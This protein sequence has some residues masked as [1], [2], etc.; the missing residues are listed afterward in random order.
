MVEHLLSLREDLGSTSRIQGNNSECQKSR[1]SDVGT[2][3]F[4]GTQD[5]NPTGPCRLLRTWG[6]HG[7]RKLWAAVGEHGA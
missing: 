1:G 4:R 2:L 6:L 7:Q 3:N 5:L